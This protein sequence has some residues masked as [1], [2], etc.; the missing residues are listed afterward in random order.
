MAGHG[1]SDKPD[2]HY[3]TDYLS[4]HLVGLLDA[5]GLETRAPVRGV[6]RRLG[7]GLDRGPLTRTGSSG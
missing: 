2:R 6:A 3:T 1:F 5:L 7:R 4:D